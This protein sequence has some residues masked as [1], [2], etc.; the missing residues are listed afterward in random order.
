MFENRTS[1]YLCLFKLLA[2]LP[3]HQQKCEALFKLNND[4]NVIFETGI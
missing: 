3:K 4:H 1:Q 2:Y